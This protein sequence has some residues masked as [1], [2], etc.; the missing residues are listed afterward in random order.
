[1]LTTLSLLTKSH[2]G[3]TK[4][5]GALVALSR[6]SST[7]LFSW[8]KHLWMSTERPATAVPLCRAASKERARPQLADCA[9]APLKPPCMLLSRQLSIQGWTLLSLSDAHRL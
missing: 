6:A 1:M 8:S 3:T 9:D 7:D 2:H 4:S 5:S